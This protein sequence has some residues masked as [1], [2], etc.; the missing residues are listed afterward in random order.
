LQAV[1]GAGARGAK[2]I[3]AINKDGEAPI[4]TA[5]D[6]AVVG[7]LHQIVPAISAEIRRVRGA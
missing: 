2:K 1:L 3:L 5:A 7:D 6:Y 4:M